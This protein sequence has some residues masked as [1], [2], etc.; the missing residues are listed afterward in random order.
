[1]SKYEK[2]I[3]KKK[4][5]KKLKE[6]LNL[7]SVKQQGGVLDGYP[8]PIEIIKKI[9]NGDT[10]PIISNKCDTL[11]EL[12]IITSNE[13]RNNIGIVIKNNLFYK[14][15]HN[16]NLWGD[17]KLG[18][19]VSLLKPIYPYFIDVYTLMNC[20]L[21]KNRTN[22]IVKNGDVLISQKGGDDIYSMSRKNFFYYIKI[23]EIEIQLD[24][25]D[26]VIKEIYISDRYD[27]ERQQIIKEKINPLLKQMH[28]EIEIEY[29]KLINPYMEQLVLFKNNFKTDLLTNLEVIFKQFFV[30]DILT[31]LYLGFCIFDKKSDNF[32]ITIEDV[33]SEDI[34]CY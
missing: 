7:L 17:F 9:L 26:S 13:G 34:N 15:G 3:K 8:Q 27:E 21:T 4:E 14:F 19:M 16:T 11:N 1:M 6:L 28:N 24:N 33:K 2:Y 25:T 12:N 29:K 5:Y 18:Y 32:M 23:D 31:L 20:E 22:R 10:T 30:L